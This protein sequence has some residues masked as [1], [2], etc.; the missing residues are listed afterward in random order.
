M[1]KSEYKIMKRIHGITAPIYIMRYGRSIRISDEF[2]FDCPK[3]LDLYNQDKCLIDALAEVLPE[4]YYSR[5]HLILDIIK[6]ISKTYS[7]GEIFYCNI[8]YDRLIHKAHYSIYGKY[9]CD[10]RDVK[11]LYTHYSDTVFSEQS[12]YEMIFE[13]ELFTHIFT[14]LQLD[15]CEVFG[16]C[17]RIEMLLK[18]VLHSQTLKIDNSRYKAERIKNTI[19]DLCILADKMLTFITL[20]KIKRSLSYSLYKIYITKVKYSYISD[21]FLEMRLV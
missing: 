2:L 11:T 8:Y 21:L 4:K 1:D 6:D 3:I 17:S 13:L 14:F 18:N 9:K 15:A 5:G 20:S 7:D 10:S 19:N 12:Y 16:N